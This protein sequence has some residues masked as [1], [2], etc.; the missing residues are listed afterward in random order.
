M[1]K[2][3]LLLK[4]EMEVP[5]VLGTFHIVAILLTLIT[6]VVICLL[7][8]N[9]DEKTFRVVIVT[10]WAIMFT[11][12]AVRQFSVS[13]TFQEDGSLSWRYDWGK[14]PL[15]LCDSPLYVLLPIALMK[16]GKVR[17]AFSFYSVTYVLL[18]GVSTYVLIST[19]FGPYVYLNVQTLAHHGLQIVSAML[20]LMHN[21]KRLSWLGFRNAIFVFL[22]V[23]TA[24]TL[25]NVIM[26]WIVP[27]QVI[28]MC[29]ISP[30]FKKTMPILNDA[31]HALHWAPTIL[32]Y[33]F[34]VTFLA[35]LLFWLYRGIFRRH[36][37]PAK[38]AQ[39]A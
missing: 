11:M 38:I 22:G 17:D 36:S 31:W 18:G 4:A 20:I 39:N 12:E 6:T 9:A 35:F 24:A 26:H 19:T 28:N 10:I 30:Y 5:Q 27:D 2:L 23:V 15:Q 29:F 32:L 13:Y 8:H 14:F 1:K 16:D 37:E 34:G 33:V 3:M 21:R 7:F 25:F